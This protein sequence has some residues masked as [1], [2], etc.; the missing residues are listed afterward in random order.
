MRFR[1]QMQTD[2]LLW[3]A[4][5]II[6]F[7][8]LGFVHPW[9]EAIEHKAGP[10]SFWG[11]LMSPPVAW[12]WWRVPLAAAGYTFALCIPSAALGW[13]IQAVVVWVRSA[14][15]PEKGPQKPN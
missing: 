4:F 13:V 10:S 5:S 11:V 6:A 12:E 3:L 9:T 1:H 8:L 15:L 7:V 2:R 14:R